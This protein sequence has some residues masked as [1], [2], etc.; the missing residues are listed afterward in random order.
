MYYTASVYFDE[1]KKEYSLT[2][3]KM[4]VE[5]E[6]PE[7]VEFKYCYF[8]SKNISTSYFDYDAFEKSY[9]ITDNLTTFYSRKKENCIEWLQERKEELTEYYK[10]HYEAIN[11]AIIKQDTDN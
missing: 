10:Q 1:Y 8:V 5:K 7:C 9:E 6:Y 11:N 3:E 2:Y 4:E